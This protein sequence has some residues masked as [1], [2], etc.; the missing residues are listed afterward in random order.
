MNV[1]NAPAEAVDKPA[2]GDRLRLQILGPLRV[3]RG[4]VEL[5]TGPRQQA[6]LLAILLTRVGRPVSDGELIDMTWGMRVP[7]SG[8]NTLRKY[9]GALRH[10][11]E[12]NLPPRRNGSY[13]QRRGDGYLLTAGPDSLDLVAFRV[14][15]G[16]AQVALAHQRYGPALDCYVQALGL[17]RGPAGAG[18]DDWASA[19][20][21]AAVNAEFLDAVVAAAALAVSLGRTE[22]VLPPLRLAATMDPLHEPVQASFI[23]AL[24]AAGQQAEAL[25]VYRTVRVRL[26]EELGIDPSPVLVTA[27]ARVLGQAPPTVTR[28]GDDDR[29]SRP[30]SSAGMVGRVQETALLSAAVESAFAGGTAV[31]VVEGE[32]GIGKTRLLEEVAGIAEQRQALVVWGRCVEG[33]GG[34]TMW[35]WVQ[36]ISAIVNQPPTTTT[37][38]RL[39]G[40][41]RHLT[42]PGDDALATPVLPDSGAQFRLFEQIVSIIGDVTAR[43]PTIVVIDDVQWA[44]LVSLQ[45]FGHLAAR[46]PGRTALIGALRDR[47][48]TPHSQLV[49]V[50][51]G[52]SRL[53]RHHRIHLEPLTSDEVIELVVRENGRLLE[54]DVARSIYSRTAGNPFFVRE[55]TRLLAAGDGAAGTVAHRTSLP[56]TVLDVVRHR[57]SGLD[58]DSRNLLQVAAIIGSD[59][60]IGVLAHAIGIDD[61]T[62]LDRL[63]P[64]EG[65]GLI[66]APV[67]PRVIRFAHDIVREAVVESTPRR[68]VSSMH[69]LVADALEVGKA[70]DDIAVERIAHHLWAAGPL[71]DP[72]RTAGAL[73][74]A[75]RAAAAKSAFETADRLLQSAV[76]LAQRA[77]L[78]GLELSA[79]SHL[80][81]VVGMRSGYGSSGLDLLQRAENLARRLGR[82]REAADL[83]FSRWAAHSQGIQLVQAAPLARRLLEQ[84]EASTDPMVRAYGWSAWGIH[85]WDLGQIDEAFRYL[86]RANSIMLEDRPGS[87]DGPLRRDLQLLWPVMLALMT[88]LHGDVDAARSLLDTLEVDAE[89][90]P[91]AI[92]VWAAFSVVT[93]A[94]AGDPAWA[95]R[96][97]D[98]GIAVDPDNSFVFLGGYQRL[99]RCWARALT[100]DDPAGAA[101]QAE[102]I[103]G[104]VLLDPPRSGLAAWYGLLCEMLLAADLPTKAAEVLERAEWSLDAHGQRYPE[105]LLLL[106]RAQVQQAGGEPTCTVTA[107]AERARVLSTERGA[108][109]FAQRSERWLSELTR[110]T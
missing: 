62:C 20:V 84:G 107:T 96:A 71:A 74:C 16:R 108:H 15:L 49:K 34:P 98:R 24:G 72:S 73:I 104:A 18:I 85:Q 110:R 36:I 66:A 37:G 26:A 3:W 12:P 7:P 22:Q 68:M 4:D 87:G 102:S 53:P 70:V 19:S 106:L 28:G 65:L 52:L 9:A 101:A 8:L 1:H 46:L 99:A 48:P 39:S 88:A 76:Y 11:L 92:T 59:V 95:S 45:M 40:E 55:I 57:M 83:L 94:L 14:L 43:R 42:E 33:N 41:L 27:H 82:E 86:S 100:G 56:S 97:A 58:D 93:A 54:P 2:V 35:P 32:P 67:D 77:G 79:L 50:L 51:A 80:T 13:L 75:G 38:A 61:Q 81:A 44:D 25:A 89:D 90:D 69:L 78:A 17:W 6:R 60:E 5:A 30:V 63:E 47:A 103:I 10:L 91:Y 29:A 31:V 64:L 109:L 21:F 105:G 23:S